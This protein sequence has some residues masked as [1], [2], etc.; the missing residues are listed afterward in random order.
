MT[1]QEIS[2]C[3]SFFVFPSIFYS[4]LSLGLSV[5]DILSLFSLGFCRILCLGRC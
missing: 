5:V 2:D 4:L 3:F 1:A